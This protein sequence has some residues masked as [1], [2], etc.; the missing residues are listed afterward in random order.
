MAFFK[1]RKGGDEHPAPAPAA[2]SVEAMRTRARHRLIGSSV[3]VLLGVIG[4]PLL[5]DSQPRPIAVDIAIEIPDKN[6]AKPLAAAPAAQ[7]S[8]AGADIVVESDAGKPHTVAPTAPVA[9]APAAR[10]PAATPAPSPSRAVAGAVSVAPAAPVKPATKPE[11]KPAEKPVVKPVEKPVEKPAEKPQTTVDDGAKAR[12]LLEGKE[13]V[14]PLVAPA[15]VGAVASAAGTSRYVV[16]IG[17][18]SDVAKAHEARV[19]LEKAGLKTYTQVV[20]PKEGKRIRVRVG[21][22]ESKAEA[23][24]VAD[25][26]KKLDLPAAILE[27]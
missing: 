7:A 13:A 5:F 25:K 21:P 15:V 27:L 11:P 24:K 10:V 18:Y 12:A 3:L 9:V 14:K 6:A 17:A 4:F 2:E 16:Q 1:F 23:D 19:K 26:I 22:F 8:K 20:Q